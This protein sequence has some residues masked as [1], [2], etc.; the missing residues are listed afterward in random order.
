MSE[1]SKE[2]RENAKKKL[3]K[4]L[5]K[6]VGQV[7]AS[8]WKPEDDEDSES[9]Q[10]NRF[11]TKKAEKN[12]ARGGKAEGEK[13]KMHAGRKGRAMG[14]PMMVGGGGA[15]MGGPVMNGGPLAGS[16]GARPM[17][18][19]P[20]MMPGS[21]RAGVPQNMLN[22]GPGHFP[23][24]A[25]GGKAKR[26]DGG[27]TNPPAK[28]DGERPT[29]GRMA[30]KEGGRTKGKTNI[31]IIIASGKGKD[32]D[33]AGG[34]TPPPMG[35]QPPMPVPVGP[36]PGAGGPPGGMPQGMPVQMGGSMPPGGMPPGMGQ[37]PMNKGGR[38]A[39]ANGGDIE[40]K[41]AAGGGKGR[42]EKARKY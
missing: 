30:R 34:P 9:N 15:P 26:A 2:C 37:R 8:D 27:R 14:G 25:T 19:P 41:Y 5:T 11:P 20:P 35:K 17:G 22:F 39:R 4:Y 23:T 12:L 3:E 16:L 33:M 40:M 1:V 7:D 38:V 6:K 21:G 42:L 10:V 29:G 32:D 31:N 36:P 13:A 18:A 28:V 24:L